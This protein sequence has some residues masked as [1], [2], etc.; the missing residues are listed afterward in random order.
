MCV[1][2]EFFGGVLLLLLH[3]AAVFSLIFIASIGAMSLRL[4]FTSKYTIFFVI[5]SF[6][7]SFVRVFYVYTLILGLYA[8]S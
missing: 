3:S 8:A 4:Y 5:H 6:V 2:R 1:C 7:R